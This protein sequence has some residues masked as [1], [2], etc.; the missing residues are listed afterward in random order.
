MVIMVTALRHR[1]VS[2]VVPSVLFL[3]LLAGSSLARAQG[4]VQT[5][6]GYVPLGSSGHAI[7]DPAIGTDAYNKNRV[8][9][10]VTG[11]DNGV[12]I[13]TLGGASPWSFQ[14]GGIPYGKIAVS[15][16]GFIAL[17]GSAQ[18]C[19]CFSDTDPN[20]PSSCSAPWTSCTAGCGPAVPGAAGCCLDANACAPFG[21]CTVNQTCGGSCCSNCGPTSVN[22]Q[23]FGGAIV[24]SVI[25]AWMED[26]DDTASRGISYVEG[27]DTWGAKYLT[28]DY[29]GVQ[30]SQGGQSTNA[31]FSCTGDTAYNFSITLYQ[32]QASGIDGVAF[33]TY[34]SAA[35]VPGGTD[36]N[37]QAN[38]G[39][40][41]ENT[42]TPIIPTLTQVENVNNNCF[43]T[44]CDAFNTS[45]CQFSCGAWPLDTTIVFYP[46]AAPGN[47]LIVPAPVTL[48]NTVYN[49]GAGFPSLT[50]DVSTTVNNVGGA[51]VAGAT[52]AYDVFLSTSPI[53]G[54][55]CSGAGFGCLGAFTQN[56]AAGTLPKV[57]PN[58]DGTGVVLGTGVSV[59]SPGNLVVA[60]P[61]PL[62]KGTYY[63][64]MTFGG[65]SLVESA[66]SGPLQ[67][68]PDP[69][70]VSVSVPPLPKP[71]GTFS[72]NSLIENV[73]FMPEAAFTYSLYLAK[74]GCAAGFDV[75]KAP[76]LGTFQG[77]LLDAVSPPTAFNAVTLSPVVP[78]NGV[79][80]AGSYSVV[81]VIASNDDL[82]TTN[83]TVCS[84]TMIAISPP[85]LK[86]LNV[87][88]PD[89]CFVSP[90]D[91]GSA[92]YGCDVPYEITNLGTELAVDFNIG[93]YAWPYS[94]GTSPNPHISA[95]MY[96]PDTT[97]TWSVWSHITLGGQCTM[98]VS[99]YGH[100]VSFSPAGCGTAPGVGTTPGVLPPPIAIPK[101]FPNLTLFGD[102][103]NPLPADYQI[104]VVADPDGLVPGSTNGREKAAGNKTTVALAGPDLTVFAGDL[105]APT[106]GTAGEPMT[107]NKIIRNVGPIAGGAPY[108][109]YLSAVG[110]VGTGG[111][112][113][114]VLTADG[115]LTFFPNT[116]VLQPSS[117]AGNTA[118]DRDQLA[119]TLLLP[120]GLATGSYTLTIA[121][122]PMA[123]TPEVHRDNKIQ[124]AVA[125]IAV[126]ASPIQ[127][128][129]GSLPVG[130]VGE[131][132]PTVQLT[133]TG[134]LGTYSWSVIAGDFA[135]S[136]LSL[137]TSGV[138]SGTPT[139]AGDFN[140]A[141]Q[142]TSGE[143]TQV[144]ALFLT[145]TTASGPLEIISPS[146][147]PPATVGQY[148]SQQ[149]QAQGGVPPYQWTG[150]APGGLTVDPSGLLVGTPGAPTNGLQSFSVTVTDHV[151]DQVTGTLSLGVVNAAAI[152]ISSDGNCQSILNS[153]G[154]CAA[155]V[156]PLVVGDELFQSFYAFETDGH[157]HGYTWTF[158]VGQALPA[159]MQPFVQMG[160]AF[161]LAGAPTQVGIFPFSLVVADELGRTASREFVLVVNS[162]GFSGGLEQLPSATPGMAYG[163]VTLTSVQ[164]MTPVIWSLYSG[165]L[166]PG[167]VINSDGTVGTPTGTTVPSTATPRA[168]SFVA[169]VETSGG[170]VA[171][172]PAS[173]TVVAPA[174]KSGGC[175]SVDGAFSLLA[176]A[177]AALWGARR[178]RRMA[179]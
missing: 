92:H 149:L 130:V 169:A 134:G 19:G 66:V 164:G 35:T 4:Y 144:I 159:G 81:L 87:R 60:I 75:T 129:N 26:L 153:G 65:G 46:S 162:G 84:S 51:K 74:G 11:T 43:G 6:G 15:V 158:P 140:F 78:G 17:Q 119:D 99:D 42:F 128:L 24:P 145:V 18:S 31:C 47:A 122:D 64:Q 86:T 16:D 107:V 45:G 72:V 30:T 98:S 52:L 28:I 69:A 10:T 1:T 39:A 157:S 49:A 127:V 114:S 93:V 36:D 88:A 13:L 5:P 132:Y 123:S 85:D 125:P 82:N 80:Q 133:A 178:T 177:V 110:L 59:V 9:G 61:P 62:G 112:P 77:K 136:G 53:T 105:V 67:F 131:I 48:V 20:A 55:D 104:A 171:L 94:K 111:V 168:Y 68:G 71:D 147:L 8:S 120:A 150:Q 156:P 50:F 174:T 79:L 83:N 172:L 91:G 32:P 138:I 23:P 40:E 165:E 2:G 22:F 95:Q 155:S 163:P 27:S 3:T 70:A 25:A 116:G 41:D 160:Q 14:F 141:A 161:V 100:N 135:Q 12:A 167:I 139:Q 173:I 143:Q 115:G 54:L 152:I 146:P 7:I 126:S 63:A 96:Y 179:L 90:P 97:P 102:A 118:A 166:P 103:R 44:E 38:V 176:L 29:H 37:C 117:N 108:A 101:E 57:R 151:G 34:G 76:F 154:V 175:Q 58:N 148:Y 121:V 109:Y 137:S 73:G 142:V 21:S 56:V 89:L 124:S 170:G 113:V 33:V 106:A